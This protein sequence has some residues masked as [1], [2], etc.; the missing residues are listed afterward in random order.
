MKKTFNTEGY[1]DPEYNYMVDL[2]SRLSDIKAMVDQGKYFTINR[3]RQYGKTTTLMALEEYL[4]PEYA[5]INMD[6]Q[7]LSNA[8]FESEQRFVSAFSREI[9]CN[10]DMAPAPVREELESYSGSAVSNVTLSVLFK[11]IVKLCQTMGK[12][13]VLIIDEVDSASNNQ[14]FLDFLAQLRAYYLKRRKVAAFQSVIL[15]G[16]YDVRSMKKKIRPNEDHREN[17]PWNIAAGFNID[18]S[19][20]EKDIAGMLKSY[21]SDNHT[22]MDIDGMAKRIFDYTHGYPYLVSD[23]CKI[24][25]ENIAGSKEFPRKS[26]AWTERGFQEALKVITR[27]DNFLYESLLGKLKVNSRL[28]ALLQEMLFN[29]K[30]IP[31]VATSDY[32]KDAAMFGF[33][34]N[35]NETAVISNR[36][37]ETVLYNSFISEEF[38]ESR[39][40]TA[41]VQEKNQFI[42]GGHL[43][44]RRILEKF[45]DTFHELY[46][47]EDEQFLENA[48]RKYFLLFLKPIINGVG[49]YSIEPQTRNSERM[50]LVI[51]YQGEQNILELKIWRGNAYNERGESQLSGYLDYFHMKKGYMLSFNFNKKKEAG[52]KEIVLGDKVLVEAVV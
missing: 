22:D 16:V 37:F 2:S 30:L 35:D 42:V 32:V 14:V 20:S 15:A 44:I 7:M 18:M 17:S 43:D 31:Y 41:G 45:I 34:R 9:L 47:E 40:Y 5:V 36:I 25:D 52:I 51:Y 26:D 39:L 29:G 3:G 13:I 1:C 11:T 27:E 33:I 8:D 19:F 24:L 4:K 48:G 38:A 23:L 46:G 6:F 49:N 21:E 28:K 50:D 10:M 12:R